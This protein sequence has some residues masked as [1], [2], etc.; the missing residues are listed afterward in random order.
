MIKSDLGIG[1]VP[2]EFIV[3]DIDKDN[4]IIL[5]LEDEIPERNI[6][7][8]KASGVHLNLAAKELEKMLL[9]EIKM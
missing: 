6:C 1:F 9:T 5:D 8:V 7:L 2:T 3:N 4:L